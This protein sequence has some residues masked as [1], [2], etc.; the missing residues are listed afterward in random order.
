[1]DE[2]LRDEEAT[3]GSGEAGVEAGVKPGTILTVAG[4]G[5][6]RTEKGGKADGDGGKATAAPLQ[7]PEGLAADRVG[8]W[9][10]CDGQRVRRVG[11]D[12]TITTVAGNGHD[13]RGAP[14]GQKA[15]QFALFRPTAVAV[16]QSGDLYIAELVFPR[17]DKVIADGTIWLVAGDGEDR[18]EG[19]GKAHGDGGKAVNARLSSPRSLAVDQAGNLFLQDGLRVRKVDPGGTIATVAGNGTRT[20]SKDGGKATESGFEGVGG[21]AVDPEGN[22]YIAEPNGARVRKVDIN[23][24]I[25]TVAGAGEPGFG[26]DGGKAT[27]ARLDHP[28]GLALD[29]FGNLYIEDFN[30]HRIRKVTPDGTIS[31]MAGNGSEGGKGDGGPATEAQLNNVRG[32]GFDPAGNLLLVDQPEN[33]V[34]VVAGAA[35]PPPPKSRPVKTIS[36]FSRLDNQHA[37]PGEPFGQPLQVEARDNNGKLVPKAQIRFEIVRN[38]T[39]SSFKTKPKPGPTADVQTD[40]DGLATAPELLAGHT[41]GK[42]TVKVTAPGSKGHAPSTY[43]AH[44]DK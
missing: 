41:P 8:N 26:G 7:F 1:M 10:F 35:A 17:V 2:L 25:T 28:Y 16:A 22:L 34:R 31:T 40:D 18:E 21:I 12:G 39:G 43:T 19:P 37:R 9:F 24:V 27:D 42:F 4:T 29:R 33:R 3:A 38:A 36:G 20:P 30:N 23:G 11:P 32:M 44:V 15:T 14:S 13:G 5:E 6:K